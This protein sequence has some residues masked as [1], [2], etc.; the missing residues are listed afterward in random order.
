[1][2]KTS[3]VADYEKFLEDLPDDHPRWA[4]YDF[5]YEV[6]DGGKRNKLVFI[7]WCAR[8]LVLHTRFLVTSC[9]LLGT[10]IRAISEKRWFSRA[11]KMHCED[12]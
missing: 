8:A 10:P 7:S 4:V 12:L 6:E 3:D 1:M 9:F 2:E 11:Q 5:H